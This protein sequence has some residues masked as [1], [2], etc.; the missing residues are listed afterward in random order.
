MGCKEYHENPK[1]YIRF[2]DK[3]RL[4]REKDSLPNF[5]GKQ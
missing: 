1:I 3:E 2:K 5:Y 4:Y